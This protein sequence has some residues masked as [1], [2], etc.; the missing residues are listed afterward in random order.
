MD[1]CMTSYIYKGLIGAGLGLAISFTLF[2]REWLEIL[3]SLIILFG[4]PSPG[5]QCTELCNIDSFF[6]FR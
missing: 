1:K 4:Y 3:C 5:I 6:Y 2:K